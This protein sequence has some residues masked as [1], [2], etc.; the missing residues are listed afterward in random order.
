LRDPDA[1]GRTDQ[2]GWSQARY[3]RH[4]EM[5]VYRHLKTVAQRLV[6]LHRRRHFERLIVAGP[7]E[8]TTE[9]SRVLPRALARRVVAVI[10]A[11]IDAS[12]RDTLDKVLA[13]E[14]RIEREHEERLLREL[15][16]L[17]GPAGRSVLGVRPTLAALWAN[18]VQILVVAQS[19]RG[20]ASSVLTVSDSIP[21]GSSSVPRGGRGCAGCTTSSTGPRSAPAARRSWSAMRSA[22]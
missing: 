7:E 18:L 9:L 5:H 2:G 12:V 19:A 15:V 22:G 8:A 13:V 20:E 11:D 4:H 10:P 21:A 6:E 14:R 17:A 3:Q 16:D 1:I